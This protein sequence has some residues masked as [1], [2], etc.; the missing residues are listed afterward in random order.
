[1]GHAKDRFEFD[2][3]IALFVSPHLGR[4]TVQN[5]FGLPRNLYKTS[6]S[7][8]GEAVFVDGTAIDGSYEDVD[9]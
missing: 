5:S 7:P 3:G 9:G 1:M 4:W 6:F 8:L 2:V